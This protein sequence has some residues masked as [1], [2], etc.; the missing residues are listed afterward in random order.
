[1]GIAAALNVGVREALSRHYPW[2]VLFDQDSTVTSGFIE[3]MARGYRDHPLRDGVGVFCPHYVD[4]ASGVAV[5]T[6]GLLADG[7]P[8][9]AMT[10][11]S[12]M[13]MWTFERCG[14]FLEDLFVDQ[15][16]VEYCFR[17]RSAGYLIARCD[18]ARLLHAAGSPRT[19]RVSVFGSFRATH[20][21][22]LRRYY[23]T[24]NRLWIVRKYWKLHRDW[25]FPILKSIVAD[26]IKLALAEH[27][28]IGKLRCTFAGA[29]D[30]MRGRL[31]ERSL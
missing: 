5:K 1:M 9:V 3:A 11:G 6:T 8:M 18:E 7:S 4:R 25:C 10:S 29:L 21:S 30:A 2:V 19:Y 20:H 27:S 28:K 17:L 15:V 24:R 14:W 26:T 12:L 13:P 16:D 23:I 31:G 22:P